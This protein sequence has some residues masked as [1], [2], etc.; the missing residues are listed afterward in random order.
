MH[1]RRSDA[2]RAPATSRRECA[3]PLH[4]CARALNRPLRKSR[5][6]IPAEAVQAGEWTSTAS[7]PSPASSEGKI[8]TTRA[9]AR[10][11]LF[12]ASS[13]LPLLH[14]LEF[15]FGLGAA[16][17]LTTL[18]GN[19]D[20]H[21]KLCVFATFRGQNPCPRHA[22][23]GIREPFVHFIFR[24]TEPPMRVALTEKIQFMRCEIRNQ[25]PPARLQ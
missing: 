8:R 14:S 17:G 12:S 6:R 2:P 3:S 25:Q 19:P 15:D 16:R 20:Q 13:P 5:I 10:L 1:R 21:G 11:C 9:S 22:Q 24:E 4:A 23:P 18:V 7:P